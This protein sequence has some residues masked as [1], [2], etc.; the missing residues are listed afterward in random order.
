MHPPTPLVRRRCAALAV[1]VIAL[2]ADQRGVQ[3]DEQ[4]LG[5]LLAPS[6]GSDHRRRAA[7]LPGVLAGGQPGS[8][9]PLNDQL[10]LGQCDDRAV[11]RRRRSD[12]S[13]QVGLVQDSHVPQRVAAVGQH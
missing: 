6:C 7:Y 5:G 10:V 2:H 9:Q 13:E 4:R 8:A 11:G 3:V 1:P 12:R